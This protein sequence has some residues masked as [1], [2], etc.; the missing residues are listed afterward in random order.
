MG[1][2]LVVADHRTGPDE[3]MRSHHGAMQDD[4]PR[5]DQRVVEDRAALEVGVVSD[6]AAVPDDGVQAAR[7][8]HHRAVLHGRLLAD[9]DRRLVA[10]QDRRRPDAGLRA[11]PH[12]ADEDGVRVDERGGID[13]RDPVTECIERH[14]VSWFRV[15]GIPSHARVG[16]MGHNLRGTGPAGAAPLR[17]AGMNGGASAFQRR[18]VIEHE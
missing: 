16:G 6:H 4:R 3:R 11:D 10:P 8:V 5:P 12:V 13:L 14:G 9:D 1:T 18:A 15:V 7:A 17:G 2:T